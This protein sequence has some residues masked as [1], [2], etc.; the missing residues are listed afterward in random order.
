[1]PRGLVRVLIQSLELRR[2]LEPVPPE[3]VVPGIEGT[4]LSRLINRCGKPRWENGR[5]RIHIQ[6]ILTMAGRRPLCPGHA[7]SRGKSTSGEALPG[8]LPTLD[9]WKR[10]SHCGL[11]APIHPS[12]GFEGNVL[13][14]RSI[15][16]ISHFGRCASVAYCIIWDAFFL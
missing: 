4:S 5:A 13:K 12:F 7:A 10:I 16:Y 14:P 8:W 3:S 1:M 2:A 9:R 15:N 11:V 6:G